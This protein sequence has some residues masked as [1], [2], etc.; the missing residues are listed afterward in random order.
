MELL[1]LQ[2]YFCCS[3]R[4]EYARLAFTAYRLRL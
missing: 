3:R 2:T 4:R 1:L